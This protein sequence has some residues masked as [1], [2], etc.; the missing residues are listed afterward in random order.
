[1]AHAATE[2]IDYLVNHL[3]DDSD[4]SSVEESM[5]DGDLDIVISVPEDE[6]GRIIGRQGRLIRSLRVLARASAGR[7]NM[8]ASLEISESD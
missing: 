4:A 5:D 7:D 2:Y 6:R 3:I 8:R 1:M